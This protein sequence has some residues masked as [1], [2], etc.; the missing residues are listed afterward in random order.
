[1]LVVLANK[2]QESGLNP[3][4]MSCVQVLEKMVSVAWILGITG[5]HKDQKSLFWQG[6]YKNK[7]TTLKFVLDLSSSEFFFY[8]ETKNRITVSRQNF[9]VLVARVQ[10]QRPQPQKS[11]LGSS[12]GQDGSCRSVTKHHRGMVLSICQISLQ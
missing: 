12:P 9:F 3:E 2:L 10:E 6:E 5:E 11:V 8:L 4:N 1:M 7:A